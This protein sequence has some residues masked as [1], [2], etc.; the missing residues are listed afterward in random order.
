MGWGVWAN[1]GAGS[2]HCTVCE[3]QLAIDRASGDLYC[4]W[5]FHDPNDAAANGLLN[6]DIWGARSTD[7]G[8]T[9]IEHHNI[10]NSPSPGADSGFCDDDGVVSLGEDILAGDTLVLFYMNDKD[11][12]NAAYPPD[13]NASLT[14]SPMLFYLYEWNPPGIEENKTGAPRRLTL[15]IAPNPSRRNTVLSYALPTASNVSIKLYSVDGRLVENVY[16]GRRDAGVYTANVD[17]RQLANGTYFV[18]LETAG[19]KI[20]RSLVVVR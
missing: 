12:G 20:T 19:E 17:A 11:A 8:A 2:N 7:N 14:D 10:T 13:P 6:G 18:M 15:N 1:P 16:S 9:W 5:V 3:P 4:V